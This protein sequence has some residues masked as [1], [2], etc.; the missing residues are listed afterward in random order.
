MNFITNHIFR[1]PQ[2]LK[3]S[4]TQYATQET[5]N[6][7]E[8]FNYLASFGKTKFNPISGSKRDLNVLTTMAQKHTSSPD[9]SSHQIDL[10]TQINVSEAIKNGKLGTQCQKHL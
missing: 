8:F 1:R 10:K 7:Q 6:T 4:A 3:K 2:S 5:L 9:S